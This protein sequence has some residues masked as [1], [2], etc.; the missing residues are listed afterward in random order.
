MRHGSGLIDGCTFIGN[1]QPDT[2]AIDYD[3]VDDGVVRNSVIHSFYGF[4][5]DGI[6]LGEGRSI[7]SL[8]RA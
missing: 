6:D 1:D 3:V 4:N 7:P 5:S 8:N 2:D